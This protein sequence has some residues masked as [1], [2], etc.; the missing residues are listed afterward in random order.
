MTA[1]TSAAAAAARHDPD[2]SR[3]SSPVSSV[4]MAPNHTGTNTHTSF[5]D[6]RGCGRGGGRARARRH[7][8]AAQAG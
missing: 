3:V 6:M 2:T 1:M 8:V 4:A 5:S 7:C